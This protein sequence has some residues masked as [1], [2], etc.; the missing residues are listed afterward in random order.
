MYVKI[1]SPN[2]AGDELSYDNVQ[3]HIMGLKLIGA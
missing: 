3:M 2:A 1:S